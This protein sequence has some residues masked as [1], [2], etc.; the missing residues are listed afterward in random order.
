MLELQ[1]RLQEATMP[2]RVEM[3]QLKKTW[4]VVGGSLYFDTLKTYSALSK[5]T[6]MP[7]SSVFIPFM[8]ED[9]VDEKAT[10]VESVNDNTESL[11][12]LADYSTK[13]ADVNRINQEDLEYFRSRSEEIVNAIANTDFEDG[14]ENDV[15]ELIG[16]YVRR[17]KFAAYIWLNDLFS[18][19]LPN[20]SFIE[21]LLRTIAMV[22]EKGDETTLLPI[23][24]AGLRSQ[25]S[26]EQEAAIMV[27]EEWRTKECLDAMKTT[28]FGNGWLKVYADKVMQE[29]EKEQTLW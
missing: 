1:A 25:V 26:S 23:V 6:S 29:L 5:L 13:A 7:Y 15:T 9:E 28:D 18:T 14:M 8:D 12:L 24:I 2:W 20:T 10:P 11:E 17:N 3:E 21:G 22:T 16:K 27:I 19:N 4:E